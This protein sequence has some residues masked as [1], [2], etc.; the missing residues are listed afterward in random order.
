MAQRFIPERM[1]YES[2]GSPSIN[3]GQPS[4]ASGGVLNN[5]PSYRAMTTPYQP[6]ISQTLPTEQQ[7]QTP[8]QN[9]NSR[10]IPDTGA[11]GYSGG[12]PNYVGP[13]SDSTV[14]IFPSGD[15]VNWALSSVGKVGY[16]QE[17][18]FTPSPSPAPFNN[19]VIG[20][21][22]SGNNYNQIPIE[23]QSLPA[24]PS[25]PDN[26]F[27]QRLY[28]SGEVPA[29]SSPF[30]YAGTNN[31]GTNGGGVNTFEKNVPEDPYKQKPAYSADSLR[32]MFS[33]NN[34]MAR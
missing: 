18:N 12:R 30:Q 8:I 7:P 31:S 28:S 11:S 14:G 22:T 17:N 2:T 20:A 26:T 1:N 24:N 19:N 13:R 27:C 3:F 15:L 16:D 5:Y 10:Y 29:V 4:T 9:T 25:V 23:P 32:R 6:K 33:G 21:S 34:W